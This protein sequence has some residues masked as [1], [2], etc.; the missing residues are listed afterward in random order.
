M[1]VPAVFAI[2]VQFLAEHLFLVED[3]NRET[4]EAGEENRGASP[5]TDMAAGTG[6][7]PKR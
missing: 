4:D 7:H 2:S 1:D 5:S 6:D 3:A